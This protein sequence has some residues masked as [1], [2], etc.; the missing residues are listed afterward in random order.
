MIKAHSRNVYAQN[1]WRKDSERIARNIFTLLRENI[2]FGTW[3]IF[4]QIL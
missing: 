2:P 1:V 3:R 4:L